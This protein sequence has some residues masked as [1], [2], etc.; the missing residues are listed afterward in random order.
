M[1]TD[2]NGYTLGSNQ[3]LHHTRILWDYVDGVASSNA[4]GTPSNAQNNYAHQRW[5]STND[6][7]STS[8]Y[9]ILSNGSTQFEFDTIV[10]AAHNA[11]TIGATLQVW[12][13]PEV[14]SPFTWT[15]RRSFDPSDDRA[16]GIMMNDSG[17]PYEVGAVRV[18]CASGGADGNLSIGVIRVGIALQMTKPLPQ[19][20]QPIGLRE[21]KEVS[22]HKSETGVPPSGS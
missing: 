10:L 15:L 12:T 9:W 3:P 11:R 7:G 4:G 6:P 2:T 18:G 19:G 8:Q 17:S 16:I 21:I 13:A 14:S 5:T 22:P 1:T 20:A